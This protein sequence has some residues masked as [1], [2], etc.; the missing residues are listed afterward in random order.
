MCRLERGRYCLRNAQTVT[1]TSTPHTD[2]EKEQR[3]LHNSSLPLP[4]QADSSST[5]IRYRFFLL[6]SPVS[7]NVLTIR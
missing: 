2:I 6:I 3:A 7:S 4:V 1:N 5:W